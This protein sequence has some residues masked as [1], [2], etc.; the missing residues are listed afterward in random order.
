MGATATVTTIRMAW[1]PNEFLLTAKSRHYEQSGVR[2]PD[3]DASPDQGVQIR[4][5]R[6]LIGDVSKLGLVL[7]C[8]SLFVSYPSCDGA[9]DV[10]CAP[11][12]LGRHEKVRF[13]HWRCRHMAFIIQHGDRKYHINEASEMGVSSSWGHSSM[14]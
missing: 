10:T 11:T 6:I 2:S 3:L 9:C 1:S 4:S 13:R 14:R 5:H 8:I 12:F 7:F